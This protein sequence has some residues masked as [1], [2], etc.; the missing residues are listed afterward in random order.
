MNLWD[1]GPAHTPG[2]TIYKDIY[3]L[4]SGFCG[5]FSFHDL[6]LANYWKLESKEH[7]DDFKTTCEK[8]DYLLKDSIQ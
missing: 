1:F 7:T 3:E 5:V 4:K 6:K 8:I 2:L